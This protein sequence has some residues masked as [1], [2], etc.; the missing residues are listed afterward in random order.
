MA[1][2]TVTSGTG[3]LKLTDGTNSEYVLLKNVL[4][5]SVTATKVTFNR[6]DAFSGAKY[7]QVFSITDWATYNGVAP[8]MS[9]IEA[10]ILA[11]ATA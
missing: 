3:Y 1:S 6:Y 2:L 8:V 11:K 5:F 9:V 10:D 7:T 4:N